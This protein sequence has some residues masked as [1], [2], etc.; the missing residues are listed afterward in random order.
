MGMPALPSAMR[1]ASL[2]FSL[3]CKLPSMLDAGKSIAF[4]EHLRG[5]DVVS[6]LRGW[7]STTLAK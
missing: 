6:N 5:M 4:S 1:C 3:A 7:D 2:T